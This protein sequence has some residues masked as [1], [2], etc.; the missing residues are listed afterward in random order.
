MTDLEMTK[1]CADAIGHHAIGGWQEQAP[2]APCLWCYK[3]WPDPED[4]GGI[5]KFDPINDDAQAMAL[6]KRFMMDVDFFSGSASIPSLSP[7]GGHKF[8]AFSDES[9]NRAIVEC[10]AKMQS[11]VVIERADDAS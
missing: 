6:A 11:A 2:N 8:I 4:N 10:V 7:H 3:V 1:L 5:F 9:I